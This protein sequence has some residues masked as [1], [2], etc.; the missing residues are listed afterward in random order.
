MKQNKYDDREFYKK[1]SQMPRSL[2]GLEAAGEW[3]SLKKVLPSF[4]DKRVLDLGCGFGWHCR[5]AAKQGAKHVVGVDLSENMLNEARR[6][7]VYSH[8]HYVRE[9]IEDFIFEPEAYDVVISSLA[10]HYVES[11]SDLCRKIRTS[12]VSKGHFVFSVEHP[13]FTAQGSQ[14]W[15]YGKDGERLHWPVD[16]YFSEGKRK[17]FFLAKKFISIIK[18]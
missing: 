14:E 8:V 16:R 15:C 9:S 2:Y 10:L 6:Q 7:T 17:T 18:L 3:N 12:L 13:V 11:F 1:Y 5:Y 4:Q